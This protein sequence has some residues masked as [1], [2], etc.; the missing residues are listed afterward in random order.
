MFGGPARCTHPECDRYSLRRYGWFR[1]QRF[2]TR[3]KDLLKDYGID[4]TKRR[5]ARGRCHH[6]PITEKPNE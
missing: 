5:F 1:G 2:W 3:A 4:V 6:H